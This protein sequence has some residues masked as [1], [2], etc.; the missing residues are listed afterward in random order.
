MSRDLRA[1][2]SLAERSGEPAVPTRA[3]TSAEPAGAS[4]VAGSGLVAAALVLLLAGGVGAAVALAT[5][6]DDSAE[7]DPTRVQLVEPTT[8]LEPDARRATSSGRSTA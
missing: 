2:A 3:P 4:A 5:G 8:D 7:P 1:A 6:G